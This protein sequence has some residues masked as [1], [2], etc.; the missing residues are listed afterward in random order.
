[1][2]WTIGAV[3]PEAIAEAVCRAANGDGGFEQI[4]SGWLFRPL[5]AF[6][7]SL[8]FNWRSTRSRAGDPADV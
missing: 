3:T 4:V 1:M 7:E 5:L 8:P 6:C 2:P